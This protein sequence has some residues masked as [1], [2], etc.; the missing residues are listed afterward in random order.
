MA[1]CSNCGTELSDAAPACPKC[2]HPR[3]VAAA[4]TARRTEGNAI[5][6][7]ILG[8]LGLVA[9]WGV[10]SIPAII[11]GN[12]A[13]AKIREDPTLEGEG[14]ARAGIITGWVGV[15]VAAVIIAVVIFSI[16][17]GLRSTSF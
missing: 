12:Q 1:Y 16:T 10:L 9:C 6:S 11:L 4:P 17:S 13:M 15:A 5:A 8:I 3:A 7:L 2:G 14:M